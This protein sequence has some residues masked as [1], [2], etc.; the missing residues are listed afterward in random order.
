M[1]TGAFGTPA[2]RTPGPAGKA[3]MATG[4]SGGCTVG[5][6]TRPGVPM[7]AHCDLAVKVMMVTTVSAS[8]LAVDMS[9]MSSRMAGSALNASSACT[10]ARRTPSYVFSSVALYAR[11]ATSRAAPSTDQRNVSHSMVTPR[12]HVGQR[13]S[14][15]GR[16]RDVAS[17]SWLH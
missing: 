8:G 17:C 4:M 14:R 7:V 10:L 9:V 6:A 13:S 12:T 15:A 5:K 2:R 16:T 1:P 11:S 3:H